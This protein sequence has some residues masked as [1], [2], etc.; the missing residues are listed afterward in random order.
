MSQLKEERRM[1]QILDRGAP[2]PWD[3][4]EGSESGFAGQDY[5]KYWEE[6]KKGNNMRRQQYEKDGMTYALVSKP[7]IDKVTP[8]WVYFNNQLASKFASK[9][10][11]KRYI[12]TLMR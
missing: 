11:A 2:Y 4:H 3:F 8:Y 9:E 5:E 6:K 12:L 10:V 7:E 1:E